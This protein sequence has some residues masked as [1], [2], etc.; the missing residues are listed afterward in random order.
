MSNIIWDWICANAP[1]FENVTLEEIESRLDPNFVPEGWLDPQLLLRR[2]KRHL[3]VSSAPK[4]SRFA[5][6]VSKEVKEAAKGVVPSN[7]KK[8]NAWAER[9]FDA[10]VLFVQICCCLAI[11]VAHDQSLDLICAQFPN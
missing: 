6:L 8:N 10:W 5:A 1:N 2:R 3:P 4:I 9:A 11:T 7:T